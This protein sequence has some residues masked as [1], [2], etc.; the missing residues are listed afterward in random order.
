MKDFIF[1][2]YI[3]IH[4]HFTKLYDLNVITI[5]TLVAIQAYHLSSFPLF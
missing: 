1:T 2:L 3:S 5:S 4:L